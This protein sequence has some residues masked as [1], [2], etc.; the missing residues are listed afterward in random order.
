M[1]EKANLSDN[2]G[3]FR[4]M[5]CRRAKKGQC[6]HTPYF[7]CREFPARFRLYEEEEVRTAHIGETKDL[8][9]MLYD[10]DYSDPRKPQP[11]FFRAQ[12]V[13]GVLDLRDCEVYR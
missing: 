4:E 10:M 8:G 9:F 7:G 12:L 1:T 11:M 2:P 3:K 6:Y 13:D 5:F